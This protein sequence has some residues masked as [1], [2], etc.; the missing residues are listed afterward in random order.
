MFMLQ[1]VSITLLSGLFILLRT[2]TKITHKAQSI[3]ALAAKW[4]I[5]ATINSFDNIDGDTHVASTLITTPNNS[6]LGLTDDE[7]EDEEDE[8]DNTNLM[9]IHINDISFQKRQALG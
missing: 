2:A 7:V 1:I 6:S 9:S 8:L 3:T 5:H 4:H